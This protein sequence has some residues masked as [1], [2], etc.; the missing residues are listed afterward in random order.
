M[1]SGVRRITRLAAATA[2]ATTLAPVLGWTSLAYAQTPAAKPQERMVVDARELVYDKDNNTVSAV[3]DVQI[4]YQG[5]TI[6]ADRVVYD[7]QSKRVVATGNARITESNG[8]VITGDR[9]NLTD[10]FRDGFI[11]S[12]RVVNTDKTRFSAPRAER[13]DGEVFVFDKGIYTACEPCVDQPERPPFWQVRAARI[14]HK[15]SEQMIYYEEARLEFA[16]IPIAYIP[17]MSGPDATVKRKTGFLAPKFINTSAL[18]YGVGLPYFINLAPNYDLTVTPTYLSRQGLLGEVEW[19]HRFVN[20]SYNIRAAGIFQQEKEAFLSS[21]FGAGDDTFRGSVES[22]GKVFI[23]PRWNFSWDVAAATDRF[24]FKNYRIRSESITASTYL[25]EST[26]T[27]SLNGQ[28]ANAWFD[29]RGYY[30]QPL[31]YYDWQK[32]QPVVGPVVD[33]NRRVHKPSMIGGELSFTVN[34]THLT[35]EAASFKELPVQKTFLINT[36]SYSLFDGCAVYQKGQCL[37]TGLAGSIARATAEVDWRRN[38]VDPI[39]QVW[40]PYASLRADVFSLNPNT[41]SYANT[42]V[43]TIADTSDEVFG[44]AMPAIG[45]MYRFP[46]VASTS[47]GTHIL[48][49]VAQVVARPNETNSLRV[50]NEDSQS[51]VFDDT[52]LFEWNKFSGYDRVEGGSRANIGLRYSGTFGQDAYAN[53]LFGQSYHLGGRNSYS[54]GDLTNTG[55][56][57]GLDTRRS[58]YVAKAQLQPFKGLLLQAGGRFN[59]STFEPQRVDASAAFS[60][61]F[62]ST[63]VGYSRYEPQPDLGI[64][65]RREG[66]SLTQSVSFAQYWSV[67]GSVL[68]DLDKFKYDRERY[69]D[70]LSLYMANPASTPNPVYP[71]TGPFQ[72]AAASL[73]LRY[74]DECTIFDVSYSQSYADRQAGS[75]KD[76]RTVMFRLELR[77]LGEIS[78]SQNLGTSSSG[79]GVASS[80]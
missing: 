42:H 46:F 43:N 5:R 71:N 79:D 14:I 12:L 45:L 74:Q 59:E 1:A 78:Y 3:G 77:T 47:W 15:K 51:L 29:M 69:R 58:D 55:L 4:L 75:T 6:E 73:G 22:S 10:D 54:S 53:A 25:Q 68:F 34:L 7:R 56:N 24:F 61:K 32:Q 11:D 2:L 49:P 44:R 35:R 17:F 28:T 65:R 63:T 72:T 21:P 19:R 80:N 23:N 13:T 52:N 20:G 18:G 33:Y 9:F 30:F 48:E 27:V 50:A 40:T 41:T 16:G 36:P 67:R 37:V 38:F 76:T 66:L 31:T 39:G 70:A 60:Y 62:L 64:P 57:S 26:S 8:T